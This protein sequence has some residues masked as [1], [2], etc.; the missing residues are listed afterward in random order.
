MLSVDAYLKESPGKGIGL[1]SSE[2]LPTGTVVHYSEN[3][4]DRTFSGEFVR[5]QD[6]KGFFEKY[7][8]YDSEND[9]YYLCHDNARFINHSE[10]PNLKYD[11]ES[12]NLY[13]VKEI[14][15]DEELTCDYRE[16]CDHDKYNGVSF[17]VVK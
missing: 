14:S 10:T 11:A 1:F 12:K 8:T 13:A 5:S 9:T 17:E 6:F 2:N 15:K 16:I 3:V 4:F 7:S